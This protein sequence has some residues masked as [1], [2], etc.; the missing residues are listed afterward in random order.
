MRRIW[1]RRIRLQLE[2]MRFLHELRL[3]FL[4]GQLPGNLRQMRLGHGLLWLQPGLCAA[5]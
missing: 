2:R 1:L 3:Q 5:L 4:F